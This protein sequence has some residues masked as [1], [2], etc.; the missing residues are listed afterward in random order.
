[1]SED[2]EKSL[3]VRP[4]SELESAGSGPRAI[5]SRMVS[6]A[7]ALALSKERLLARSPAR[8]RVGDDEFCEP[9]YRQLK[10]WGAALN[11]APEEVVIRFKRE[12]S[13]KVENGA[14]V[15][16]CWNFELL[17]LADFQWVDGLAIRNLEFTG[18][19]ISKKL[20]PKLPLLQRLDCVA[21]GLAELELSSVPGLT[22]LACSNNQLTE[23]DLSSVPGLTGLWCYSNPLTELDLSS[24]PGLTVLSCHSD[25]L[26]ELDLSSVPGLTKLTC[27]SNQLTE[28]DLSSVPRIGMLY[29]S[30]NS[31]SMLDIRPCKA[32]V[33]LEC[34]EH[35]LLKKNVNQ[36]F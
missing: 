31:I 36:E 34:G 32:L 4:R 6:D 11:L 1:M 5:L 18:K 26:T 35:V 13:F 3:I 28:L 25:Q 22:K 2:H 19:A 8:F 15:E 33:T 10:L 27:H 21:L 17:P 24:V 30:S 12:E 29:C 9:D 16:L 23:L 14:I 7:L 20:S